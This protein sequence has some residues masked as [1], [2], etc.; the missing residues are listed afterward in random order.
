MKRCARPLVVAAVVVACLA[1]VA[2]A[3]PALVTDLGLDFWNVPALQARLDQDVRHHRELDAKDVEVLRRIEIKEG[4]IADLIAGR[5]S[6]PE[7]TTH[8]KVL[9][10]GRPDY[11]TIIRAGYPGATDDERL[12]R[13]VL[14]FVEAHLRCRRANDRSI[15]E[16]LTRE[17]ERRLARG[18]PLTLPD[19]PTEA[20]EPAADGR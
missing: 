2:Y 17:L 8:F 18:E 1:G 13:N 9:N 6:L 7:A 10:I 5:M 4:V 12:S 3:R 20:F 16:R 15:V 19:V 11:M 14:A